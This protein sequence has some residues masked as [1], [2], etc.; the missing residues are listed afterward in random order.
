M[1]VSSKPAEGNVPV[2]RSSTKSVSKGDGTVSK[3]RSGAST[4]KRSK[5]DTRSDSDDPEV[6]HRLKKIFLTSNT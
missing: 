5:K 2:V 1:I 3:K 6:V 4:S